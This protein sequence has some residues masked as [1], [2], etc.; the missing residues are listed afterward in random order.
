MPRDNSSTGRPVKWSSSSPAVATVTAD[1]QLTGMAPGKAKITAESEGK[2]A[3]VAVTVQPVPVAA[4]VIEGGSDPL[5]VGAKITSRPSPATQREACAFRSRGGLGFEHHESRRGG[6]GM[7]WSQAR[8]RRDLTH[9]DHRGE[10]GGGAS[11]GCRSG[12]HTCARTSCPRTS[13]GRAASP[14][15]SRKPEIIPTPTPAPRKTESRP[16]PSPVVEAPA[17]RQREADRHCRWSSCTRGAGVVCAP[18]QVGRHPAGPRAPACRGS[19][20]HSCGIRRTGGPCQWAALDN[21]RPRSATL[22]APNCRGGR[23]PGHR[24]TRR[25]PRCRV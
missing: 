2:S 1:G 6:W 11:H 20:R 18:P 19:S 23:W 10:A 4:V 5:L 14:C 22:R 17:G 21:S 24:V 12:A 16:Q 3:T 13:P 7:A 9:R 25:W 8:R 15:A